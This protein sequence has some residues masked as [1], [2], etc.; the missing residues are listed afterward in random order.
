M[1]DR[2][3]PTARVLLQSRAFAG[4]HVRAWILIVL[5]TAAVG[6]AGYMLLAG[7]SIGDALYMTVISLTTV[8]FREVRELDAVGRAWTMVVSI[9]GVALIFGSVGIVAEAF[10]AEAASGR[11]EANRMRD[12]VD[13]LRDHYIV[14]GYGRVG[15]TVAREL[16][17]SGQSF[18]VIDINPVSLE[19]A[20]ADGHLIVEGDA[21]RDATLRSAGIERARGLITTIDSDANNV[22]VTLSARALNPRLF[23]VA[24]ANSDGADAKLAQ[25]G[26]DR[27]VSPYTRAGRQI[28]DL[29]IRPRVADFLDA[30]LSHGQLAFS[31]EEVEVVAGSG[32]DGTTVEVL[33]GRGL[34]VLAIVRG[35]RDYEANPPGDRR[36][37]A[38]EVLVM[39]G[40]AEVLGAFRA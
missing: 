36:L 22:Y 34:H 37:A 9:A 16:A 20:K 10:V 39:S 17:H 31:M 21:T 19:T 40:S 33:R 8:G 7:W 38:G 26:A 1:A 6:T 27:I 18:V 5:V 15:S 2:S 35:E 24:R 11:R 29:A 28:A 3:F 13:A 4:H 12:A 23:I 14:C 25:A 32:L 30:A